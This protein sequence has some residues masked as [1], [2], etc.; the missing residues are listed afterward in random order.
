MSCYYRHIE[1][2]VSKTLS[3]NGSLPEPSGTW[4]LWLAV[5]GPELDMTRK[6]VFPQPKARDAKSVSSCMSHT[7]NIWNA[8]STFGN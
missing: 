3:G 7:Q 6:L 8:D 1:V 4:Q 5:P 2:D